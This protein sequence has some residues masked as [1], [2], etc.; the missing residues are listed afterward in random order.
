MTEMSE[1]EEVRRWVGFVEKEVAGLRLE[2]R[3]KVTDDI[4]RVWASNRQKI[5]MSAEDQVRPAGPLQSIPV[6]SLSR[7]PS[8]ASSSEEDGQRKKKKKRDYAKV[9]SEK[10]KYVIC[11]L[12]RYLMSSQCFILPAAAGPRWLRSVSWRRWRPTPR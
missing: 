2:T 12:L 8:S 4:A 11:L 10:I 7:D 5:K 3:T 1:Q 9:F 6:M